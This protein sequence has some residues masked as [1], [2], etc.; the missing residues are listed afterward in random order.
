MHRPRY[1]PLLPFRRIVHLTT[2][3][4]YSLEYYFYRNNSICVFLL[5]LRHLANSAM[6]DFYVSVKGR[7]VNFPRAR[8]QSR[9]LVTSKLIKRISKD[10]GRAPTYSWTLRRIRPKGVVQSVVRRRF[11]PDFQRAGG[12]RVTAVKAS[13]VLGESQ[14]EDRMSLWRDAIRILSGKP[15][16]WQIEEPGEEDGW[17]LAMVQLKT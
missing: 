14:T 17:W 7:A 4:N 11:R 1:C 6:K 2:T 8:S 13:V 12:D 15:E 9:E 3:S 5:R 10:K 16:V